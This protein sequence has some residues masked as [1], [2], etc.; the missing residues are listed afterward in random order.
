MADVINRRKLMRELSAYD[1]VLDELTL[2]LDSHPN[3]KN[4]LKMFSQASQK[5]KEL[6]MRYVQTYGPLTPS[7]N[8]SDD[9]WEWIKGPWPW[10]ND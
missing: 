8:R 9:T 5:A 3:D 6:R 4:A 10:E 1:F 2:Y 7:E